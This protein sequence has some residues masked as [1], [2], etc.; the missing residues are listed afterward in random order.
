MKSSKWSPKYMEEINELAENHL[1][2]ILA[3]CLDAY[4]DGM[5]TGRRNTLMG[6]SIG[7]VLGIICL[8]IAGVTYLEHKEQS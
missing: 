6:T 4:D 5:R 8:C 7:A 3:L 2:A 1:E